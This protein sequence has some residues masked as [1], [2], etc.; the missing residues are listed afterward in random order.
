MSKLLPD[1]IGEVKQSY[2]GRRRSIKLRTCSFAGG[3][4]GMTPSVERAF[5]ATWIHDLDEAMYPGRDDL[6]QRCSAHPRI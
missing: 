3:G 1:W 4:S 2:E 6:S 5:R